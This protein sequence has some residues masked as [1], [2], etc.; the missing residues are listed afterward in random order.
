VS[1]PQ[2]GAARLVPAL[3]WL[4]AYQRPWLKLDAVAAWERRPVA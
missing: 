3:A 4:A 1:T 2:A